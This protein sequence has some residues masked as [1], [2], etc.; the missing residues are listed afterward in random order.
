[1]LQESSDEDEQ[2]SSRFMPAS[3]REG[4]QEEKEEDD[5]RDEQWSFE[6]AETWVRSNRSAAMVPFNRKGL[7]QVPWD[8]LVAMPN[9]MAVHAERNQIDVV[10]SDVGDLPLLGVLNLGNDH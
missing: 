6:D 3:H 10:N 4:G 7:R 9:L 1:M 8:L 5:E 2:N